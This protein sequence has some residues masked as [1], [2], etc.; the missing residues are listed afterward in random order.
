MKLSIGNQ[1]KWV[2]AAGT[3]TGD[4]KNIVLSENAADETIPW[5]DIQNVVNVH[6]GKRHSTT[7]LCAS[8]GYLKQM[9]VE[10]VDEQFA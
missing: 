9:K 2:S 5:I 4:I 1:V 6:T 8:H 7:R 3:L 10:L